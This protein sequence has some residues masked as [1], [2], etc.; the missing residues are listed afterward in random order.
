VDVSAGVLLCTL[1]VCSLSFCIRLF[2][3]LT[4]LP[5]NAEGLL[6]HLLSIPFSSVGLTCVHV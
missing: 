4:G 1:F 5:L 2:F 3:V 6:Y